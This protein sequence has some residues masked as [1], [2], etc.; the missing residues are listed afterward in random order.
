MNHQFSTKYIQI[1][2]INLTCSR[3]IDKGNL[4]Q[5]ISSSS[6][7]ICNRD[8]AKDDN[9]LDLDRNDVKLNEKFKHLNQ[10]VFELLIAVPEKSRLTVYEKSSWVNEG[11][12]IKVGMKVDVLKSKSVSDVECCG[13]VQYVGKVS[14]FN[15]QHFG[16]ELDS[17]FRGKGSC[18]GKFQQERYFTC[19]DDSAV[20]CCSSQVAHT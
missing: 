19:E 3:V 7:R 6:L 4:W 12:A 9:V 15:G 20:F 17:D 1:Q 2:S 5:L 11:L 18:N 16:V 8:R 13:T 10:N 14:K